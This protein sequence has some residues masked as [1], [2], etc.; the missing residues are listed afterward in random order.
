MDGREGSEGP[1]SWCPRFPARPTLHLQTSWYTLCGD[2][3]HLLPGFTHSLEKQFLFSSPLLNPALHP[4][5]PGQ[6]K[7]VYSAL[8][9]APALGKAV[10]V[11]MRWLFLWDPVILKLSQRPSSLG[12]LGSPF[13]RA[14]P[15]SA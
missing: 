9:G 1:G 12:L 10:C 6:Q 13:A 2:L 8:S 5:P 15:A 11:G 3:R 7:G 14:A 4:S